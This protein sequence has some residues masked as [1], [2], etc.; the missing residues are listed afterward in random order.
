ME[1]LK[2]KQ[3][4]IQFTQIICRVEC[5]AQQY[6][7]YKSFNTISQSLLIIEMSKCSLV[8]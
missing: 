3:I 4:E 8:S 1:Q 5:A 6:N 2:T 7:I